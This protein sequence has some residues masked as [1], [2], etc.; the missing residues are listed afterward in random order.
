MKYKIL[1]VDDERNILRGL[2]RM[3]HSRHREW[4]MQFAN[5]GKEALEMLEKEPAHVIIADIRMPQMDGIELLA[6]V[7]EAH[8]QTVR[9][10]L[11]AEL[12]PETTLQ[13][14]RDAHQFIGKPSDVEHIQL[15]IE[16]ACCLHNLLTDQALKRQLTRLE[17]LPSLPDLYKEI[18]D[19][20]ADP[21]CTI[22][23]VAGIIEKDIGI[24]TKL[25]QLVNSAFFGIARRISI[26]SEAVV[27][28]GIDVVRALV[29]TI[30]LFTDFQ[31]SG[32]SEQIIKDVY[33]HSMKT[34]KLARD[35]ALSASVSKEQ[36]DEAF[37]AGL[38]H[39]IGKLVVVQNVPEEYGKLLANRLVR[40]IPIVEEERKRFGTTHAQIGAYLMGLWGFSTQI[41]EAVAFHHDPGQFP[42]STFDVLGAVHVSN[43]LVHHQS[44]QD[45]A[46]IQITGIDYDYLD[47]VGMTV[48]LEGWQ[49]LSEN[50]DEWSN[51]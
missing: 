24:T 37:L 22:Q 6:R 28:L 29:L 32:V 11:S 31:K 2:R 3:L 30:G 38:L 16:R 14:I 45:D 23:R 12:D 48:Q 34:G 49:K 10:I 19:V 1:F 44:G 27:L 41:V 46:A 21:D 7:K 9:I 36:A 20:L 18:V 15:T 47:K 17:T 35:I 43:A 50:K 33:D 25:L 40:D 51:D 26:P 4:D 39:D 42:S 5:S 13:T 8:P